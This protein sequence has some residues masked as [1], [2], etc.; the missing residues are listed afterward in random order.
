M[1]QK[2]TPTIQFIVKDI[3]LT[4]WD[5]VIYVKQ[6]GVNFTLTSPNMAYANGNTSVSCQ[7]TRAQSLAL[8]TGTAYAQVYAEKDGEYAATADL[9]FTIKRILNREL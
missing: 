2:T 6:A 1:I 3:D 4:D 7:L 8:G 5:V 9:P